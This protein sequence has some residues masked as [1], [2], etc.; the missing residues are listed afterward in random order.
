MFPAVD[1]VPAVIAEAR[2]VEALNTLLFVV[3]IFVL[4][5]FTL[6]A[7]EA[8]EAPRLVEARSVC[9]L[10]ADVTPDVCVLVFAFTLAV[11]ALI[12][13]ANDVEALVN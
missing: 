9:A 4:A 1:A 12:F 3:V 11:P 6:V 10:T 5:V 7:T 8:S 2:E 13:A